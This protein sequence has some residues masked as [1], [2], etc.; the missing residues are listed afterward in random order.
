MGCCFFLRA[1]ITDLTGMSE[2][3]KQAA[4]TIV[5]FATLAQKNASVMMV[6]GVTSL[7]NLVEA[8][9]IVSTKVQGSSLDKYSAPLS[10]ASQKLNESTPSKTK[11][12]GLIDPAAI[13][14]KLDQQL[15]K[16]PH[17]HTHRHTS[18]SPSAPL[19]PL[20]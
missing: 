11:L 10:A 2:A 18:F 8:A 17:T 13:R 15:S 3:T 6:T 7:S 19:R 16:V 14:T 12:D 1:A 5:V 9:N 20:R 4:D